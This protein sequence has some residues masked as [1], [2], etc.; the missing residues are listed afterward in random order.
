MFL[1]T[2][3]V[4]VAVRVWAEKAKRKELNSLNSAC[5]SLG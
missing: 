4:C 3:Q 5:K 1:P 2:A